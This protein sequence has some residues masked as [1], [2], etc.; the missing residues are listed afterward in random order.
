MKLNSQ[1][2]YEKI[3]LQ[4]PALFIFISCIALTRASPSLVSFCL[5]YVPWLRSDNVRTALTA[6][7]SSVW[8]FVKGPNSAPAKRSIKWEKCG[9]DLQTTRHSEAGQ[10]VSFF[11]QQC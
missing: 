10:Q 5:A 1:C 6:L 8:S 11:K 3:P 4:F 9:L 7:L 2:T